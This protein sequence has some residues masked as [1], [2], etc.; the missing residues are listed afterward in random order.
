MLQNCVMFVNFIMLSDLADL[1]PR[2]LPIFRI[3]PSREFH[4]YLST[5]L[6]RPKKGQKTA[7]F[8]NW[9]YLSELA[10]IRPP[11]KSRFSEFALSP[12]KHGYF[13]MPKFRP[14]LGRI[15][16]ITV[17]QKDN[18]RSGIIFYHAESQVFQKCHALKNSV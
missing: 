2:F 18:V 14:I 7:E 15:E 3:F 1:L 16:S 11:L 13:S 9:A 4:G 17:P 12:I 8:G 5:H 6:F 10:E